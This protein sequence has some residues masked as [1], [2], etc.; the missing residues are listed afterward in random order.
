MCKCMRGSSGG[1]ELAVMIASRVIRDVTLDRFFYIDILTYR[2][3][4]YTTLATR[5][6]VTFSRAYI[7]TIQIIVYSLAVI[8]VEL[9]L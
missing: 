1:V 9:D 3:T 5:I 2:L 6:K 7:A 4:K 8:F